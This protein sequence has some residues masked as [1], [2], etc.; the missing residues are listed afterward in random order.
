[1][2]CRCGLGTSVRKCIHHVEICVDIVN[3]EGQGKQFLVLTSLS[4][5][6]PVSVVSSCLRVGGWVCVVMVVIVGT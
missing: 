6:L 1:M 4:Q 5:S 2:V 3:C